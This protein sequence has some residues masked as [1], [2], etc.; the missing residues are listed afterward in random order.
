MKN[1]YAR[2]VLMALGTAMLWGGMGP[3]AK[4]VGTQGVSMT[5][6]MCY[7]AVVIVLLMSLWLRYRVGHG[8]YRIGR[9]L[10]RVYLLLGFLTVVMNAWGFMLS[11]QYLSVPQALMLNYTFPIA[12]MTGSY[13]ITGEKPSRKQLAAG[14]LIIG[15]LYV[16]F[17][18]SGGETPPLSVPGLLWG[19][20]SLL[21][22]SGQMLLSRKVLRDGD[23]NPSLQLFYVYLFGGAMLIIAKSVFVGW[24][25]LA[26][27]NCAVFALMQY[28]AFGAGL[29][30]F[31]LLLGALRV[32]PAPLVS[33][34]LTLEIAFALV[35][36]PLS[37]GLSPTGFEIAGCAIVMAAV[38]C[39][40][41]GKEASA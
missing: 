21:G 2:G 19:I 5:S 4:F 3:L 26:A 34:V 40:A 25:D 37:L 14:F 41:A 20:V 9:P 35:I 28:S 24:D 1:N 23:S 32:I 15:G 7:R 36:T 8:W 13:F 17:F 38:A 31:G 22:L 29:C 39:A 30:G 18:A 6:V 11:C 27:M 12:V 16:G 33:L 10:M